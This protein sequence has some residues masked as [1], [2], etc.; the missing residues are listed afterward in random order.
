M[1]DPLERVLAL[2]ESSAR[3]LLLEVNHLRKA[4]GKERYRVAKAL[5]PLAEQI[6]TLASQVYT[7][8]KLIHK[9]EDNSAEALRREYL[10]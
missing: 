6:S 7:L 8:E 4:K 5:Q 9:D 1:K 2:L 3:F 10:L